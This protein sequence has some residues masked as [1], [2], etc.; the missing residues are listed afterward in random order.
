MIQNPIHPPPTERIARSAREWLAVFDEPPTLRELATVAGLSSPSSVSFQ[1]R[2]MR[3]QACWSRPVAAA[4]AVLTA[5][6]DRSIA[7][8]G[9]NTGD[10][11]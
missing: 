6:T 11:V 5:A 1:L 3:E 8:A 7:P 10:R 4:P 2:R 9:A